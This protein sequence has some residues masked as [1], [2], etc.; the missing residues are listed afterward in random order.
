MTDKKQ[1]NDGFLGKKFGVRRRPNTPTANTQRYL[2]FS[3][4][5]N[6]TVIMKGGGLRA[7]LKVEPINFN[8]K[9][10][11]EQQGIIAGYESFVNTL[12]FPLQILI[13]STRVNI[14]PYLDHIH[15]HSNRQQ[16]ALLKEQTQAYARFIERIVEVADIMQKKFFVVIPLD[17]APRRA[18][19]LDQFFGWMR[20]TDDNLD[21]VMQRNKLLKGQ[22][23]RLKERIDLVQTG[24]RNIGI[25]SDRLGTL[26]LIQ[27][28][29]DIYNHEIAGTQ[30][31]PKNGDFNTVE[32]VL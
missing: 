4:I 15:Q 5:R 30:K 8:L 27:L 22:L 1:K 9:S 18:N 17:E 7:I 24:L 20:H 32:N 21:K 3:E 16:S 19:A 25:S 12:V 11:T 23:P 2:P 14:E 31:L 28:Y 6:D 10:E 13:R 29:Y 26:E